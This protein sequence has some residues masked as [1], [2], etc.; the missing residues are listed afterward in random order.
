MALYLLQ[1]IMT[2]LSQLHGLTHLLL[3]PSQQ[4]DG[5]PA[6]AA[7]PAA[8]VGPAGMQQQGTGIHMN[9]RPWDWQLSEAALR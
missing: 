4:P 2:V 1:A 3:L 9:G 5:V 8:A 6:G 7:G